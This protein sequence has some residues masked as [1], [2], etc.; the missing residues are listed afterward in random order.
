MRK[1]ASQML[2]DVLGIVGLEI[3]IAGHVEV[4]DDRHNLAGGQARLATRP[5]RPAQNRLKLLNG[6]HLAIIIDI[7]EKVQ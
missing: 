3:A 4:N 1:L 2:H 6:M 5:I 7:D